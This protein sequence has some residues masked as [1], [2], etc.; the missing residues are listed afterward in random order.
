M[1]PKVSIHWPNDERRINKALRS[2]VI[3]VQRVPRQLKLPGGTVA[4]VDSQQ[5][6]LLIGKM[7]RIDSG[8]EVTN[9]EGEK[10]KGSHLIMDKASLRKPTGKDPK[11][12]AVLSKYVGAP[13][14]LDREWRPINSSGGGLV[15]VVQE[16]FGERNIEFHRFNS[17]KL[18]KPEKDLLLRYQEWIGDYD[19]FSRPN[20]KK[21]GI[22]GDLFISRF[23]CLVE[24]KAFPQRN[25]MR[26][27]IGQL[28]DYQFCFENRSPTLAYLTTEKPQRSRHR[29]TASS[30]DRRNLANPNRKIWRLS[31]WK[32]H[33]RVS[34]DHSVVVNE[35]ERLARLTFANQNQRTSNQPIKCNQPAVPIKN[36][37]VQTK[38][39]HSPNGT[40]HTSA[41]SVVR[42]D[43]PRGRI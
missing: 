38:N 26:K 21:E 43:V 33:H 5:N 22:I 2:G 19:G 8:V 4:L 10:A 23:Y 24:A 6:V 36:E 18:S 3:E 1:H 31:R 30:K 32:I 14:Y 12:L 11:K 7:R 15:D 34:K 16:Q 41:T 9:F 27:A 42:S 40:L 39:E 20:F 28:F 25:D 37:S 35:V 29:L 17:E 13:Y